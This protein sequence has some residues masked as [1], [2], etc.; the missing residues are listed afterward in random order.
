MVLAVYI[1]ERTNMIY[2]NELCC[3]QC[4]TTSLLAIIQPWCTRYNLIISF[5]WLNCISLNQTLKTTP[6]NNLTFH[7]TAIFDTALY[8]HRHDM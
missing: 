7:Y 8:T 4:M 6:R 1:I 2:I 5:H 3:L